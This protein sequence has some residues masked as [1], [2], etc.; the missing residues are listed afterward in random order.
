MKEKTIQR[1]RDYCSLDSTVTARQSSFRNQ[2]SNDRWQIDDSNGKIMIIGGIEPKIKA[3]CT[4][5][6]AAENNIEGVLEYPI[7]TDEFAEL[8]NLFKSET[9]LLQL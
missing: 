5:K 9:P 8:F 2:F 6:Y 4:A 1:F 7:T 3:W